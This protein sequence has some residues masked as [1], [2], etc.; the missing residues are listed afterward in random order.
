MANQIGTSVGS[1][2]PQTR[3]STVHY[4]VVQ[5]RSNLSYS[6]H[7]YSYLSLFYHKKSG[8]VLTISVNFNNIKM[9]QAP[10]RLGIYVTL[11][12]STEPHVRYR[13]DDSWLR[14]W[15]AQHSPTCK[16][17]ALNTSSDCRIFVIDLAA[18]CVVPVVWINSLMGTCYTT[19][20]Y[21]WGS[22]FGPTAEVYPKRKCTS[23][24]DSARKLSRHT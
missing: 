18:R 6:V 21:V 4:F 19:L 17:A 23:T 10:I 5:G 2:N 11:W 12:K 13:L 8:F 15:M 7:S 1:N 24:A 9:R 14:T 22:E 16:P 3:L 20:N